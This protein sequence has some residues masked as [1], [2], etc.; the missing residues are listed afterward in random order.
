[1]YDLESK[2]LA[3]CVKAG[4]KTMARTIAKG[5]AKAKMEAKTSE[6]CSSHE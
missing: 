4:T 2:I 5:K 6:A 1:M 3:V